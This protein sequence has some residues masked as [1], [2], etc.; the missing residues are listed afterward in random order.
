MVEWLRHS[1]YDQHGLGSKSSC[2]I[3]LH[4][5][6]RHFMAHSLVWWSWLEIKV[7]SPLIY[8][9]TAKSWHLQKQ[10]GVIAYPM[11]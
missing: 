3:L 1:A 2:T 5:W 4:P 9:Q 6:E 8:K 10:V 11:Y 7:I